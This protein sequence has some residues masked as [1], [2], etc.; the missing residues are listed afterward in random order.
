MWL[1]Y[2]LFQPVMRLAEKTVIPGL[3]SQPARVK[4]RYDSARTPFDRLCD[5]QTI[6]QAHRQQLQRLRDHTNP[7]QLRQEIYDWIDYTFSLPG[8]VPGVT[9]DVHL[10]LR[11]P[12]RLPTGDDSLCLHPFDRTPTLK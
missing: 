5:T 11:A 7:R 9:E 4:Y 2:N 12:Y 10:T 8:A 3:D 1:Y 6:T